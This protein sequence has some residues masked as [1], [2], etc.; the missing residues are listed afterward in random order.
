MCGRWFVL[1]NF[2][3]R[4]IIWDM[5]VI[6]VTYT[7]CVP[8][9]YMSQVV[10]MVLYQNNSINNRKKFFLTHQRYG[11]RYCFSCF[12]F[13]AL[14]VCVCVCRFWFVWCLYDVK[15]LVKLRYWWGYI[16]YFC[17]KFVTLIYYLKQFSDINAILWCYMYCFASEC[18]RTGGR[19]RDLK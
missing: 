16:T 15:S 18:I 19:R 5:W 9:L 11:C 3:I 6:S 14:R 7:L 2:A 13:L 1:Y 8:I 4:I 17:V 10:A 12:F